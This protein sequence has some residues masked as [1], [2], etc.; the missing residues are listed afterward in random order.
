M[1]EATDKKPAAGGDG[2]GGN[3]AIGELHPGSIEAEMRTSYLAY[4]MSVIIGRALPDV[5]DGLKPVHRRSLFAMQDLGNFHNRAYKTSA[6]VVGDVIGKYHPH[7]D[8]AVYEA[9]VRLAQPWSM[10]YV[11]VETLPDETEVCVRRDPFRDELAC[12]TLGEFRQIVRGLRR[13][14][15]EE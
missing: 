8:S 5:R 4:S 6:R 12:L 13:A 15:A 1:P 14:K 7:G 9:I 3:G 2:G 10:R 11:L